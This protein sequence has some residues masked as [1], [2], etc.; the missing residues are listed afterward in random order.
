MYFRAHLFCLLLV[1][2]GG[3]TQL[4][5]IQYPPEVDEFLQNSVILSCQWETKPTFER[6]SIEWF[7]CEDTKT[8]LTEIK[9]GEKMNYTLFTKD[10][11]RRLNESIL[12]IGKALL[13]HRG[14]YYCVVTVEIPP[15]PKPHFGNGTRLIIKERERK[16]EIKWIMITAG[17]ISLLIAVT[18]LGCCL[19]NNAKRVNTDGTSQLRKSF[20]FH[21]EDQDAPE[22]KCKM[23][24]KAAT[25]PATEDLSD[26]NEYKRELKSENGNKSSKQNAKRKV[27]KHQCQEKKERTAN[28]P[29]SKAMSCNN[30]NKRELKSEKRI[31]S[32][33]QNGNMKVMKHQCQA[34]KE[35]AV[36]KNPAT[37]SCKPPG[38]APVKSSSNPR[39]GQLRPS[40]T[41]CS[42]H[43]KHSNKRNL[44][45]KRQT[46]VLQDDSDAIYQNL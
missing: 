36:H 46:P 12:N 35:R 11:T 32:S 15:P 29:A 44:P 31:M 21:I 8:T 23:L 34:K 43:Q 9:G 13:N 20:R 30:D 7:K 42:G 38:S 6:I 27:M 5:I 26:N 37:P 10:K 4:N 33:K 22:S 14:I 25:S 17:G 39:S 3:H 41:P 45:K 1:Y 18:G 24:T 40:S 2:I 16:V 19:R 28:N